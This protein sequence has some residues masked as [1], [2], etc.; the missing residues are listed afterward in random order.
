MRA[1]G[2]R[3]DGTTENGIDPTRLTTMG[4][5]VG[6]AVLMVAI[7]GPAALSAQSASDEALLARL[8]AAIGPE[9]L[10][11]LPRAADPVAR[12]VQ[13]GL[14]E[15]DQY[16]NDGDRRAVE[17]ALFRFNQASARRSDW[18]WPEYAMAHAF[19]L[20]HDLGAPVIQSEGAHDGEPHLQTMWRHLLEA[21]A[22]DP[23]FG[24]ARVLLAQLSYPSGDRELLPGV[25]EALAV[26]VAR[27]DALADALVTWGRH[28]RAERQ[29]E[30]ALRVLDAARARGA[31]PV[32]I[33]LERARTLIALGRTAEAV[34]EYWRGTER[35]T[36][37]GRELYRQDLGWILLDDSLATFDAVPD[38]EVAPWLRRF[39]GERGAAALGS[40]DDRVAEHLRRWTFVHT[41]FRV[42]APW[43]RRM[44]TRVDFGYDGLLPCI[45]SVTPFYERL[46]IKPPTLP[47]DVRA[48]EPLLDHRALVYMKH[49]E[50]FAKVVPPG[51]SEA[52]LPD[53]PEFLA[54]DRF[55]RISMADQV[56]RTTIWV[57]WIEGEWRAFAFHASQALGGHAPTTLSS[58]LKGGAASFEALARV[59]PDF[60][61][62]A[63]RTALAAMRLNPPITPTSCEPEYTASVQR[64]RTDAEVG[65][66][67]DSDLPPMVRPWNAALRSHAV[68]HAAHGDGRGL[69]TFAIPFADLT[70][71]TLQDGRLLW[72]VTFHLVAFRHRDGAR[73]ELDSTRHF[74]TDAVPARSNLSGV[75]ELPLADG[76]WQ[77]AILVRQREDTLGGAYALRRDLQVDGGAGLAL[78]DIVTGRAGQPGWPAPDGPFPVNTLGTWPE[79]GVVELWYEVRGVPAGE[80]YR[81]TLRV[82]P[83]E[84][85]LRDDITVATTDRA[86][87]S[88]TRVRRSLGLQALQPGRYRL[89][90][91]VEHGGATAVR[92]QE[93]LVTED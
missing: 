39:W 27:P 45:G 41:E 43:R 11:D 21:L 58:F 73:V 1:H 44:Y 8:D 70:A 91:T 16:L 74:I 4:I 51:T 29:F 18:A 22:R 6:I 31:D 30:I 68:G 26:E 77:L 90:V 33:A 50:P 40:A 81:T 17:R 69:V 19:L 47:G 63:N 89:V 60:R 62:V 66:D 2:G 37:R 67:T 72:P 13:Q 79:G 84:E 92:E 32:V 42:P 14:E 9:P 5:A 76:R 80:E 88:V 61:G 83:A 71:D 3:N 52:P 55:G 57:Y 10:P 46:P 35:P 75:F 38:D 85:H 34:A 23:A 15:L 54:K 36:V 20:L 87:G 59:V 25:A 78:T 86:A 12:Q 53:E 48:D 28:K 49:G 82:E 7:S 56:A 93:I 24:R 65:I 64:M